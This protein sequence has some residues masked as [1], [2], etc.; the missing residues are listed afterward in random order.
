M[1]V[2]QT[3]GVP[4]SRGSAIFANMGCTMKR[5]A[6]E[7]KTVSENSTHAAAF[8]AER[9]RSSRSTRVLAAVRVLRGLPSMGL[10]TA[11]SGSARP[12]RGPP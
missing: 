6:A 9:A 2:F 7:T 5:R 4:P 1:Q 11:A 8:S 12:A 10:L 3:A